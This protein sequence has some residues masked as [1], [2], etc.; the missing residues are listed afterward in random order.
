M[1]GA[2]FIALPTQ[3]DPLNPALFGLPHMPCTAQ[4][5]SLYSPIY[6]LSR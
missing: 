4:I 3:I 6:L 1:E 2:Y 5:V